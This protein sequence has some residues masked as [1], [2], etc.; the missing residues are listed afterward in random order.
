[1]SIRKKTYAITLDRRQLVVGTAAGA[2]AA[3]VARFG[4]FSAMAQEAT[5]AA[6]CAESFDATRLESVTTLK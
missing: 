2:A 1:M 3:A 6:A 5:P 4:G